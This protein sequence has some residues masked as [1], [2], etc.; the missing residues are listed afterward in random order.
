VDLPDRDVDEIIFGHL[1]DLDQAARLDPKNL[2]QI[3]AKV[4]I[5]EAQG[6]YKAAIATWTQAAEAD[7]SEGG[8]LVQR[9]LVHARLGQMALAEKD[10][11]AGRA[12]ATSADQLNR[13]C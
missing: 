8:F 1:A 4:E 9:G 10:F 11:T 13:M 12:K 3:A 5:Q 7:P 2:R 6:N